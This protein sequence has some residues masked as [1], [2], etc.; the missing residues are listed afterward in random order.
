MQLIVTLV[1]C[2]SFLNAFPPILAGG[3]H[4]D[5]KLEGEVL[6]A[7]LSEIPLKI[8]LEKLEREKGIWFK[9]DSSLL[10]KEIT[11]QFT[12]LSVTEALKRILRS[13]N[14][15]L[16]FDRDGELAGVVLV[17]RVASDVAPG[18]GRTVRARRDILSKPPKKRVND[19]GVSA[20]ARNSQPPGGP[21]IITDKD[22]ESFKVTRNVPPPGGLFEVSAEELEKFKI[23]RNVPPP[24]GP[25]EVTAEELQKFSI[26][27]NCQPPGS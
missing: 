5:L 26:I 11:V 24:G 8:I 22:L 17:G 6:S 23:V 13:M 4:I 18:E 14:Y 20:V 21:V 2:F 27:K 15:S 25:V 10:E 16:V 3:E 19:V 1:I 12:D 9:G 7:E